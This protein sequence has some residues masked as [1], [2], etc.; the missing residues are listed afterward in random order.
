[1]VYP[2]HLRRKYEGGLFTLDSELLFDVAQEMTE[3]NVKK[4]A[5]PTNVQCVSVGLE[6]RQRARTF[7]LIMTLSLCRSP[8]PRM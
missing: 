1:V 5:L 7:S 4:V 2:F 3:I 6:R 8:I